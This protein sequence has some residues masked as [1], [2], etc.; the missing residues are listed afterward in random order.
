M[1]IFQ[2]ILTALVVA[3]LINFC[4][5]NKIFAQDILP[6]SAEAVELLN[7]LRI[8]RGLNPL[9]WNP[10]SNLQKAAQLR[11]EEISEEFSH[12]RPDGTSCFTVFREF[13]LSRYR[14]CGENIAMGTNLSAEGAMELWINSPGHYKNM[15]NPD[16]KEVGL[17]CFIDGD[18]IY[19]V[20][21]FF[22]RQ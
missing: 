20:Q 21:L 12:T 13:N 16:F 15:V 8:E 19:W 17:G 14:T 3:L 10:N 9:K 5:V 1:K 6:M 4:A 18:E 22:T 2:R 7:E 11:A